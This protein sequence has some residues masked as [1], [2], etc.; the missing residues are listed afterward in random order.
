MKFVDLLLVIWF[1]YD[2]QSLIHWGLVSR[3]FGLT[4]VYGCVGL[5][6]PL[7]VIVLWN[8]IKQKLISARK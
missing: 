3:D 7:G 8:Y 2:A 1:G 5:F 6:V 4:F